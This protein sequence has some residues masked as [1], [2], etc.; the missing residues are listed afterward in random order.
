MPAA[1]QHSNETRWARPRRISGES[2]G[3]VNRC[4]AG[5]WPLADGLE[6]LD[7]A[8]SVLPGAHGRVID[9]LIE[10]RL[11][12]TEQDVGRIQD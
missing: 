10:V 5:S 2:V 9:A 8:P 4:G 7:P 11:V 1:K 3:G 12:P 6:L